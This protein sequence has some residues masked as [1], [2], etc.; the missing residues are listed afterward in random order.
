MQL[1]DDCWLETALQVAAA[2]RSS[3]PI[4]GYVSVSLAA[5]WRARQT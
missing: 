2:E 4:L 1:Q 5:S 3:S